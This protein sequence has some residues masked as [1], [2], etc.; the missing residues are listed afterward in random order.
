MLSFSGLWHVLWNNRMSAF[1]ELES[2]FMPK[3]YLKLCQKYCPELKI[4]DLQPYPSGI[5]AQAVLSNGEMVHDFLIRQTARMIHICNA[6]S[7]AATA[8]LPIGRH[9]VSLV[10][11]MDV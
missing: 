6:P 11:K 4:E 3:Q 7:P 5:R 10:E 9:I 1:S 2:S 8:S